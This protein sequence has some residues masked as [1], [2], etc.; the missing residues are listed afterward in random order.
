MENNYTLAVAGLRSYDVLLVNPV[1]DGMNLV[2]KE[3]PLVNE[4]D[5]VLVMSE[6][7]GGYEQL[8]EGCLAVSPA[9]VEGTMLAM[10]EALSMPEEERRRLRG[11]LVAAIER[12]DVTQWF[13]QQFEDIKALKQE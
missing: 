13:A 5:G 6:T 12:E 11:N 7:T 10:H 2:A 3:G 8:A 1:A 4:R 9:D